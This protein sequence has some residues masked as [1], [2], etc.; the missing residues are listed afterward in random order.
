MLYEKAI[1]ALPNIAVL[2]SLKL[3][4]KITVQNR[5]GCAVVCGWLVDAR[6][7]QMNWPHEN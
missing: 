4:V 3:M 6:F 2:T 7:Q 5:L 1:S